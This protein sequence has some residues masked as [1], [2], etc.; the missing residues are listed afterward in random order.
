[1]SWR[2]WWTYLAIRFVAVALTA[3]VLEAASTTNR[4]FV[5]PAVVS[6]IVAL[7]IPYRGPRRR[8]RKPARAA[9]AATVLVALLAIALWPW[10]AVATANAPSTPIAV[11]SRHFR[12]DSAYGLH[13]DC[14]RLVDDS[15]HIWVTAP[16]LRRSMSSDDVTL[17]RT[18][19]G[20]TPDGH[21]TVSPS[22]FLRRPHLNGMA[23]T[24]TLLTPS[25]QKSCDDDPSIY[26]P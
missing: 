3:A 20:W 23:Y 15:K 26:L 21:P 22:A 8:Y 10:Y 7:A 9:R 13:A 19:F 1:M 16:S 6:A 5:I 24:L 25:L 17:Y 4:L 18:D 12:F 11:T 2:R 14:M